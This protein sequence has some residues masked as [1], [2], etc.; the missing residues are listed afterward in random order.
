MKKLAVLLSLFGLLAVGCG[1]STG[2]DDNKQ[3]SGNSCSETDKP[4]CDGTQ[5]VKKCVRGA[6][7]SEPCDNGYSCEKG[8]CIA[9][10]GNGENGNGENG[11]GENGNGENQ[12]ACSESD[13][14]TCDGNVAKTCE[15]GQI[16][17]TTCVSPQICS[18]GQCIDDPALA[19]TGTE[20][21]VCDGDRAIKIC[22]DKVWKSEPCDSDLT[23]SKGRCVG[24]GSNEDVLTTGTLADVGKDC[25]LDNFTDACDNNQ[26]IY[27]N[28]DGK[29][30]SDDL[31]DLLSEIDEI[32][33][34]CHVINGVAGCIY[35]EDNTCS[36]VSTTVKCS[37]SSP[38]VVI[39]EGCG[40]AEDGTLYEYDSFLTI[41][42]GECVEGTGC[43][44]IPEEERCDSANFAE[45]CD[46]NQI[47]SCKNGRLQRTACD[48]AE[49]CHEFPT[50]GIARCTAPEPCEE[51][52][53]S[54]ECQYVP[55]SDGD[56]TDDY[57]VTVTC[58]SAS[59]GKS[60]AYKSAPE[61]CGFRCD[62]VKGCVTPVKD[63]GSECR[64][65]SFYQRCQNNGAV[66]CDYFSELVDVIYCKKGYTC[67]T[68]PDKYTNDAGCY[69]D[70]DSL[71][72]KAG[73]EK[74]TCNDSS[75]FITSSKYIC[76][77]MSDNALHLV[78]DD[79]EVCSSGCNETT[80]KCN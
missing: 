58:A 56:D 67:L 27:C 14:P 40:R 43:A 76:K 2:S 39:Y 24:S 62:Q 79:S 47:V 61:Y 42:S 78:F 11:N 54:I 69:H 55:T 4:V 32:D 36:E 34:R 15:G 73:D 44:E 52:G 16:V 22:V 35:E 18:Q 53:D 60:Y 45:T 8:E 50:K 37:T 20:A 7:T 49:V 38:N 13:E 30:A 23:C 9:S 33:V 28:K 77:L 17:S 3:N 48:T 68:E 51:L 6:W 63:E 26:T 59:D 29:I 19:C 21:P 41:C 72:S 1:D 70:V 12:N 64:E 74:Y 5:A 80:G 10:N 46:G 75:G 57:A 31:C 25:S 66:F 65:E 71:C